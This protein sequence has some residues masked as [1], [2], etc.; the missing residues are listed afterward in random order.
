MTK[1]QRIWIAPEIKALD[2][3][4]TLSGQTPALSEWM[5]TSPTFCDKTGAGGSCS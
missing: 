3:T 2:V 4:K 5:A 1:K